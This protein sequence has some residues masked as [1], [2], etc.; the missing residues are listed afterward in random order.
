MS[1]C[2]ITDL[3]D[4]LLAHICSY[5]TP[6]SVCQLEK[7]CSQL[8]TKM[9]QIIIW[10]KQ[11]ES[12]PVA[13]IPFGDS[14][15]ATFRKCGL[16]V[17]YFNKRLLDFIVKKSERSGR[18]N[19]FRVAIRTKFTIDKMLGDMKSFVANELDAMLT[20]LKE[21]NENVDQDDYY[22]H[23]LKT[24]RCS[25]LEESDQ[26]WNFKCSNYI[27]K[28]LDGTTWGYAIISSR[29]VDIREFESENHIVLEYFILHVNLMSDSDTEDWSSGGDDNDEE[30]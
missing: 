28:W 2:Q 18:D 10:K 22:H 6:D 9:N 3:P 19:P 14:S 24:W 16:R 7:S 12:F 13:G 1:S 8:K 26:H 27:G 25:V 30:D 11:V 29:K 4:G 17:D 23:H 15:E 21:A 5:L 20:D